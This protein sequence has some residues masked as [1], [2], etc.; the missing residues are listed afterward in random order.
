MALEEASVYYKHSGQDNSCFQGTN[1]WVG[2]I[3]QMN[4]RQII[5]I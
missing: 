2:F 1:K 3:V 5:L 4:N